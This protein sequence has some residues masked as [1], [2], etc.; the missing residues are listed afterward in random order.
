MMKSKDRVQAHTAPTVNRK[1]ERSAARRVLQ[2]A[3]QPA[4]Q[5]TRRI[6]V[7]DEEW[8]MERWLETNASALA[9]SG[10]VLG[11]F[12]NKR[13]FAIPCLV[14]PFLFLHAVQGW[15]PPLPIFRHRGVRTRREIDAEKYA[16]KALRGDFSQVQQSKEDPAS[17]A[18]MAWQAANA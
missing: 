13:F 17:A 5:I 12:V 9:F 10:T 2:A 14:L 8:D 7:L 6:G 18:H 4:T 16:L 11:L 1:I 3:G 15:C